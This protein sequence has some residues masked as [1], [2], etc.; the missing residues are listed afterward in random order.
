MN[1]EQ[2]EKFRQTKRA[3]LEASGK[4]TSDGCTLAPEIGTPCCET[5][6]YLRRFRPVD[7]DTGKPITPLHADNL[8]FRCVL[9]KGKGIRKPGY[10]IMA[11]LYW[12]A[13]RVA[14]LLGFY[15]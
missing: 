11:A 3:E 8:L 12:I 14:N 4:F 9:N 13:S 5:H 15:R 6:D 10:F 7:L 1:L 2:A